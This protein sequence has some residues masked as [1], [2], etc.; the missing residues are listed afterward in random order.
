MGALCGVLAAE[1]LYYSVRW[2]GVYG[3]PGPLFG[4]VF[5]LGVLYLLDAATWVSASLIL[6]WDGFTLLLRHE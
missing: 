2:G 1:Y 3:S 6:L 5:D 4:W